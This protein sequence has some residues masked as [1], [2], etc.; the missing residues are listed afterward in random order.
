[1]SSRAVGL[2]PNRRALLFIQKEHSGP[3]RNR[4]A[5]IGSGRSDSKGRI[6]MRPINVLIVAASMD[7]VG[8][9]AVQA[10]R[11]I[12]HLKQE[13]SV[14]V[15]FLPV[16]P[17]L[18]GELR[19]LQSIKYV[20]TVT[21]SWLYWWKLLTTVPSFDVIHIFSASYFSFLLAPTPAMIVAR[22]F[23]K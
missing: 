23:G 16:N 13:P 9:Q 1:M 10:V 18:P 15:D 17:R 4:V 2:W 3:L 14:A 12:E 21:T 7:I 19:K 5:P 11:L 22:M 6:E 20:R 8:G